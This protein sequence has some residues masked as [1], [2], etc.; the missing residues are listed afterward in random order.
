MRGNRQLLDTKLLVECANGVN[1]TQDVPSR[2]EQ[3]FDTLFYIKYRLDT[4]YVD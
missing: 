2:L 1:F 3:A 4:L